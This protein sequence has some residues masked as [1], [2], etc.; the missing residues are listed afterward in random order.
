MNFLSGS[1]SESA[2]HEKKNKLERNVEF[3]FIDSLKS[4]FYLAANGAELSHNLHVLMDCEF[5]HVID[6]NSSG[7]RRFP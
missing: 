6:G 2:Y 5:L 4:S 7:I 1:F 3:K